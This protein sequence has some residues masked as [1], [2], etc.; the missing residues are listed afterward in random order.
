[1]WCGWA[2]VLISRGG[3]AKSA[4][5]GRRLHLELKRRLRLELK[6]VALRFVECRRQGDDEW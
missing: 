3:G 4:G 5:L 1:M 2:I 6:G